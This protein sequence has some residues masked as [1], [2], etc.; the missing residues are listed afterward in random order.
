MSRSKECDE[1]E[2]HSE[3]S[4]SSSMLAHISLQVEDVYLR[5]SRF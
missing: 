4:D 5:S 2:T 3:V 1:E